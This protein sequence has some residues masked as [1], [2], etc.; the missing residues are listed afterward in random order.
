MQQSPRGKHCGLA[1]AELR[2]SGKVGCLSWKR[3]REAKLVRPCVDRVAVFRP[4]ALNG[5]FVSLL[6]NG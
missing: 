6:G 2:K 3:I 4:R 1:H 5:R